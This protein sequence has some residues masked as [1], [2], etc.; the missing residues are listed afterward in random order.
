MIHSGTLALFQR[1]LRMDALYARGHLVRLLLGT[2]IFASLVWAHY[3]SFRLTSPGLQFFRAICLLNTGFVILAGTSIFAT[4]ITEEKEEGTLGLLKM[5]GISRLGILLGKSTAR[6]VISLLL[7][8]VQLPFTMLAITLGG[9]TLPQIIAAYLLLGGFLLYVANLGLFCSV[10][11]RRSGTAAGL[12][13][14]VLALQFLITPL[15]RSALQRGILVGVLP[16]AHPVVTWLETRLQS[17]SDFS[18]FTRL[19]HVLAGNLASANPPGYAWF[20]TLFA[21]A[22]FS[23]SWACFDRFTGDVA[24]EGPSRLVPLPRRKRSRPPLGRSWSNAMMWKE[25]H[26]GTGGWHFM[27]VKVWFYCMLLLI[28][29]M[30]VGQ[31]TRPWHLLDAIWL[32]YQWHD[33][34]T[35]VM[36]LTLVSAVIELSLV[37]TCL[38]RDEVRWHTLGPILMLSQSLPKMA[39][40]KVAGCLP[41]LLPVSLAFAVGA[42]AWPT[43]FWNA[44]KEPA[45]WGCLAGISVYLHIIVLLSLFVRWGALSLSLAVVLVMGTFCGMPLSFVPMALSVALVDSDSAAVMPI[46]YFGLGVTAALQVAIAIKLQSVAAE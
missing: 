27:L 29:A 33:F 32:R 40:S 2:L 6:V 1:A 16:P 44:L 38:F 45:T 15:F 34:G 18:I 35:S 11:C 42:W 14:A 22:L 9:I 10:Y 5:A 46:A 41:N 43:V 3:H 25:F 31:T 4:P 36:L 37:A 20:S 21:A 12:T 13:A 23:L 7:L 24:A 8:A 28:T 30:V 17:F 19:Q 39:Y 26:F